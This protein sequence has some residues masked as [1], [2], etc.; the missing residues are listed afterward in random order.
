M[1]RRTLIMKGS[2]AP[3]VQEESLIRTKDLIQLF[4]N[5][6]VNDT[7]ERISG[8]VECAPFR[9]F[10]LYVFLDSTLAPTTLQVKIQFLDRWSGRWHTY[11]QGL[12]ASLF[13][14][15]TDVASGVSEAFVGDVLG[16]AVR[17]T[18]TGVG[19]TG[20]AYFDVSVSMDFWN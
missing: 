1:E 3:T 5:E 17:V 11:K 12:F 8:D 16:R 7:V 18:L 4:D 6:R 19:T 9:K 14:E 10:G 2:Q 15:D 13:W 20:T